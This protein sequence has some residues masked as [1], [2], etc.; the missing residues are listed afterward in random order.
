MQ[1]ATL[2]YLEPDLN[3]NSPAYGYYACYLRDWA[4]GVQKDLLECQQMVQ[5]TC[6]R[7]LQ[8]TFVYPS[9]LRSN[10]S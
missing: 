9:T 10:L 5:A 6:F 3:I 4:V 7:R 8:H 2:A 1:K